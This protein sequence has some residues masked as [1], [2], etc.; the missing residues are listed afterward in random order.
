MPM[1]LPLLSTGWK[2]SSAVP[3]FYLFFRGGD[4][5]IKVLVTYDNHFS[6]IPN[7]HVVQSC[8]ALHLVNLWPSQV[9]S[10]WIIQCACVKNR[11]WYLRCGRHNLLNLYRYWCTL[12]VQGVYTE[13]I[14]TKLDRSGSTNLNCCT[15]TTAHLPRRMSRGK[16]KSCKY[17]GGCDAKIIHHTKIHCVTMLC[18]LVGAWHSQQKFCK[19]ENFMDLTHRVLQMAPNSTS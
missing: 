13:Q 5:L 8:M 12:T 17:P 6:Q 4:L 10:S 2:A 11:P 1:P 14:Y 7:L 19:K 15:L 9:P 16:N 18:Q 3:P